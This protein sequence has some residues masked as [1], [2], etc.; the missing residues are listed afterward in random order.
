MSVSPT[1]Q[2]YQAVRRHLRPQYDSI[3]VPDSLLLSAFE[4]YSATFRTG[5]RYGS[6]VPGPMEHRKRLAKRHMGELHFGQSHPAA[7]IWELANL[8]DLTKWKWMPPTS[9]SD[10]RRQQSVKTSEMQ[11][12]SDAVLGPLRSFFPPRND[13]LDNSHKLDDVFLPKD[14]ILSGVAQPPL[15]WDADSTSMEVVDVG[16][17]LLSQDVTNGTG[18]TPLFARFCDTW[19]HALMEGSFHGEAV[20]KVLTSVIT[21]LDA[22]NTSAHAPIPI[23]RLKLLF[24]EATIEGVSQRESNGKSFDH[25]VWNSILCGIGRIQMNTTRVF[26]RAMA[27]VPEQYLDAVSPGILENLDALFKGLGRATKQPTL[28]RQ[29]AKMAEPLQSIGRPELRFILDKATQRVLQYVSVEGVNFMQV[30]F[31]WLQLLA[32]LREVDED[33]LAQACV[34]L[35]ASVAVKPLTEPEVCQLFL[36]WANS[37]TPFYKYAELCKALRHDGTKCYRRLS[38][39]LWYTCQFHRVKQF[40]KFLYSLGRENNVTLLAKGVRTLHRKGLYPLANL[41][42]GMRKPWMAIDILCLYEESRRCNSQIWESSLSF[43]AF[44]CL[45]WTPNFDYRKLW[46][47]FRINPGLRSRTQRKRWHRLDQHQISR[48]ATIGVVLGLSPHYSRGK[49]FSLMMSCYRYLRAHDASLPPAF[50][51]ALL[52]NVTRHLADGEPGVTSR[53]RAIL[54]IIQKEMGRAE[55]NRVAMA[56]QRWRRSNFGLL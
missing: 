7:P 4:R 32:R 22:K 12:L 15:T 24:I 48:A 43:K 11:T 27:C 49:S 18:A 35:E 26:T 56:I 40:C 39:Q 9:S 53:M 25:I 30:R 36:V 42:L 46:K 5:A 52:Y 8:V 21:G 51:R 2:C 3:W 44:E 10:L 6:S 37:K 1:S 23:D 19:Q 16:L 14:A 33:Y 28:A 17:G 38:A 47:V 41:A 45:I 55:A 13:T 29:T 34:A 54:Y 50:L 31:G 20:C